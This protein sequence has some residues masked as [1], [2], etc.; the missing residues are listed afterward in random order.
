MI[1]SNRHRTATSSG[2]KLAILNHE[3]V[4]LFLPSF[5]ELTHGVLLSYIGK[6]DKMR[7]SPVAVHAR[8]HIVRLS[9]SLV[10]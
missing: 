9:K 1:A 10:L 7:L 5:A 4:A 8:M 6:V 2:D 3:D